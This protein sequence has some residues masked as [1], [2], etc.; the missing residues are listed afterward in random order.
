V[1]AS[2]VERFDDPSYLS[3]VERIGLKWDPMMCDKGV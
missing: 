3:F 2:C 1:T